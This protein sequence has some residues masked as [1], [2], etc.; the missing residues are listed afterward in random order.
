MTTAELRIKLLQHGRQPLGK[1][2][3]IPLK[4]EGKILYADIKN[5]RAYSYFMVDLESRRIREG[6]IYKRYNKKVFGAY[7]KMEIAI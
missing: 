7:D 4:E 5:D 6:H 3:Q 1:L 2:V